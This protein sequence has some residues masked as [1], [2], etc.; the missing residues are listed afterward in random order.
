MHKVIFKA[1]SGPHAGLTFWLANQEVILGRTAVADLV[2]DQDKLLSS[3]HC[4]LTAFDGQVTVTDLNSTNGTRVNGVRIHSSRLVDGDRVTAGKTVLVV[5]HE[6]VAARDGFDPYESY[7]GINEDAPVIESAEM[8]G[9]QTVSA[10]RSICPSGLVRFS[11]E[12]AGEVSWESRVPSLL[13]ET[14]IFMVVDYS[15]LPDVDPPRVELQAVSPFFRKMPQIS[16]RLPL[17]LEQS[18]LKD[19]SQLL[20]KGWGR[21]AV[22]LLQSDLGKP[23]LLHRLEALLVPEEAERGLRIFGLCWPGVLRAMLFADPGGLGREILKISNAVLLEGEGPLEWQLF[24]RESFLAEL[25][26]KENIAVIRSAANHAARK[27]E[28]VEP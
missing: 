24:G 26:K 7:Y 13:G 8:D 6:V 3:T 14:G 11:G 22:L 23:E 21:N 5:S 15:R 4:R 18:E 1:V 12:V 27:Q 2:L 19:W 17:V 20:T 16:D 28:V 25:T 9:Q 10:V